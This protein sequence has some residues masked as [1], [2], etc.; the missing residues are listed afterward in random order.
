[1]LKFR[2]DRRIKSRCN[3]V[4]ATT[5]TYGVSYFARVVVLSLLHLQLTSFQ[6]V[7][8]KIPFFNLIKNRF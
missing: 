4:V 8:F 1:M 3:F 6:T 2:I 7:K 5:N